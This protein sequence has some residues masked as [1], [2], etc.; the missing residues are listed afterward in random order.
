MRL[1]TITIATLIISP[2]FSQNKSVE[3]SGDTVKITTVISPERIITES[4]VLTN[5]DKVDD[6]VEDFR[7]QEFVKLAKMKADVDNR[8]SEINAYDPDTRLR[9]LIPNQT[10]SI[11]LTRN[12]LSE[13]IDLNSNNGLIIQAVQ[14]AVTKLGGVSVTVSSEVR[15]GDTVYLI[16]ANS[17][18]NNIEY[19]T[20]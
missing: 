19:E 4:F 14:S 7:T 18:L 15:S 16:L 3:P 10:D 17:Q 20:Y 2:L 9:L 8:L 5:G 6:F 1:I 12:L 11:I 13:T